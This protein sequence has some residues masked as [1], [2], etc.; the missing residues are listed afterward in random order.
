[1]KVTAA[2]FRDGDRVLLMRRAADQPLAGEWEYPGGKFED[3][4]DGPTCLRRELA[5]ELGIDAQIGDLITIAK[6]TTDSGKVIELHTYEI[7]SYTGEIQLRVHDD[8][9]WVPVA[10]L[11][12]HPQLPADK[13][14]SEVLIKQKVELQKEYPLPHPLKNDDVD[15]LMKKLRMM[16]RTMESFHPQATKDKAL[17]GLHSLVGA[18][19]SLS[20]EVYDAL[21][22]NRVFAAGSITCQILEAEIQLLWLN[23]HFDT[24]GKDFIDFGY[25]EQIEM[26]RVHPDRKDRVLELLKQNNCDRFLRKGLKN[27]NRLDRNS[28]NKK[29]YGDTI[30]NISEDYFKLVLESIQDTPELVA[31]YEN[32]DINYENYQLFCGYKHFSP[33][34]VIRFFATSQSFQEDESKYARVAVLQTVLTSILNVCFVLEQHGDPILQIKPVATEGLTPASAKQKTQEGHN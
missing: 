8:M 11:P 31:Y 18:I 33:Y 22:N 28:Y 6:H 24:R 20:A 23:K 26:L 29:W 21:Q 19:I 15:T 13:K 14:V 2:I 12:A 7:T 1:M 10:D 25:V 34:L 3:G 27:P 32:K 17:M 16:V 30:Q 4:E 9:H 5:E